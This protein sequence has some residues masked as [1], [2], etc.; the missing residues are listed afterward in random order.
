MDMN[1]GYICTSVY[2]SIRHDLFFNKLK[3]IAYFNDIGIKL[4]K[5]CLDAIANNKRLWITLHN[6]K[7]KTISIYRIIEPM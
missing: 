1:I 6:K 2:S 4:N 5:E 7:E 3:N